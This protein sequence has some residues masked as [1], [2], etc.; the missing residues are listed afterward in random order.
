MNQART[1]HS[2]ASPDGRDL[3]SLGHSK[4]GAAKKILGINPRISHTC[5][6]RLGEGAGPFR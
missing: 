1:L 4:T 2:Q 3:P 5:A 6:V